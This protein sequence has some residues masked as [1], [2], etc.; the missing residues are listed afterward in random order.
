[1]SKKPAIY[2]TYNPKASHEETLAV[3]LQTIGAVNGFTTYLPDRFKGEDFPDNETIR[4]IQSSDYFVIFATKK[5]SKIVESE[6]DIAY[7]H[8]NDPSKI[9]VL[10]DISISHQIKPTKPSEVTLI[11]FD[12]HVDTVDTIIKQVINKI[13]IKEE[14]KQNNETQNGLL[15]LLGIGLGLWILSALFSEDN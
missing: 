15:A 1:M 9:I 8:F 6:I 13:F 12:S 4:R 10:H 14:S 5:L 3:R 2:I 11:E 7:E